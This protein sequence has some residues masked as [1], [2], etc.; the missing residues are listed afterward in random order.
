[1]YVGPPVYVDSL[2]FKQNGL[3]KYPDGRVEEY[4]RFVKLKKD[5]PP[6]KER[7][8]YCWYFSFKGYTYGYPYRYQAACMEDFTIWKDACVAEATKSFEGMRRRV[9]TH[10]EY[11]QLL[12]HLLEWDEHVSEYLP[13]C[14]P[15]NYYITD[16]PCKP[17]YY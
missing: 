7:Q 3:R 6:Y 12:K 17:P 14:D 5:T 1:M 10:P 16:E 2:K 9:E 11:T 4:K 13:L 8:A 15:E